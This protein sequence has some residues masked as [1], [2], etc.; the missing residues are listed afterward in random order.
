MLLTLFFQI[1][2]IYLLRSGTYELREDATAEPG[3]KIVI[4]LKEDSANFSNEDDVKG[5]Q[6]YP[7]LFPPP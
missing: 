1:S 7:F 5:S 2:A 3:T 6:S 4:H